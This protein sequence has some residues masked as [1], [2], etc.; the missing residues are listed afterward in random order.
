M[1]H[2]KFI[3]SVIC[4]S[5]LGSILYLLLLWQVGN[6][7][8]TSLTSSDS[9]IKT[10]VKD[11]TNA[12][13]GGNTTKTLQNLNVVHQMLLDSNKNS[14]SLMATELLIN[15]AI[16]SIRGNDSSRAMV[17][18][19]LVQQQF[20]I[21]ISTN[22]NARTE[23]LGNPPSVSNSSSFLTYDNPILGVKLQYPNDWTV[24]QYEYNPD[25]NNTIVGFYSP[26]K[27]ASELG[28]ISGVSG[29]FVP[30]S[31]IFV[32]DSKNMTLDKIIEGRIKRLQNDTHFTIIDSKPITLKAGLPGYVIIYRTVA[33]GDELF[34]KIQ[35][36]SIYGN[37][38]FLISFTSQDAS[39]PSY[40]PIV[41]K[42]INSFEVKSTKPAP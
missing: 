27:T 3:L 9:I 34:R 39:F 12:L 21:P 31:D 35:A 28:N 33:G 25:A 19:N 37:K 16:E 7:E 17:Y 2:L 15:D 23:E 32:F 8:Q 41:Q 14:S 40:L 29:H 1:A 20:G 26:S 10:L 6:A 30:Y 36:Y 22:E 24:R 38:V 42:M 4:F 13:S 11:A 5:C 18:L